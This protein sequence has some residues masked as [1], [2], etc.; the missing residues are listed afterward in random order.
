MIISKEGWIS[1]YWPIGAMAIFSLVYF[2]IADYM[3]DILAK[4]GFKAF[5]IGDS[6][7]QIEEGLLNYWTAISK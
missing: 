2:L 3:N 1:P 5:R 6:L 7:S 4:L